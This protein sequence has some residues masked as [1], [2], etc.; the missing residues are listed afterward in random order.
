M[1]I[2][3]DLGGGN[4]TKAMALKKLMSYAVRHSSGVLSAM[5]LTG[6]RVPWLII[7][8]SMREKVLRADATTCGPI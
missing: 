6:L 3:W 1:R 2:K 5:R 4:L 7:K 8:A